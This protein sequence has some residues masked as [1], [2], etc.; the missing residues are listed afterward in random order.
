MAATKQS[1]LRRVLMGAPLLFIALL[2]TGACTPNRAESLNAPLEAIQPASGEQ[3]ASGL[4]A[5]LRTTDNLQAGQPMQERIILK[6]ASLSIVVADAEASIAEI[7]ALAEE[8]GGWVV[9]S[10]ISRVTTQSG[11]EVAR[12]SITVRVQAERLDEALERIKADAVSVDTENVTGQ[13]VT[14]QYV[15]LTSQLHNL[16]AAERQLQSIMEDAR[17]TEDVLSVYNQLVQIRGQIETL[18]G[19]I[20]YYD[21][22]AAYS[23]ISVTLTPQ[24]LETPIQIAGWSPAGTARTAFAALLNVLRFLVDAAITLA[25]LVLPLALIFGLPAWLVYRRARRRRSVAAS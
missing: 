22:S 16:Q 5:D 12:G 18:Q 15:D 7:E 20:R 21:E 11:E 10:N 1:I 19:Q 6:S 23:S 3:P 17:R 8:F 25:I 14:Q 24:A 13:D 9:S 4:T 2:L